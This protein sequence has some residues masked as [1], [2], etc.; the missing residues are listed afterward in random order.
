MA[1]MAF[2]NGRAVLLIRHASVSAVEVSD[3]ITRRWPNAIIRQCNSASPCWAMSVEDSVELAR[4]RRGVE[5]LRV[6][7]L[8]QRASLAG[9]GQVLREFAAA[10]LE[11]MPVLL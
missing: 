7:V 5:P 8:P 2:G 9:C 6:V 10:D 3:V 1:G 11:P 4:T